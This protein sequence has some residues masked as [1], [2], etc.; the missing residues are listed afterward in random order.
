MPYKKQQRENSKTTIKDIQEIFTNCWSATGTASLLSGSNF[1]YVAG[2]IKL[3]QG[4]GLEE[5]SRSGGMQ[6]I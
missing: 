1:Q 3:H 5:S 4:N 2:I 6:C